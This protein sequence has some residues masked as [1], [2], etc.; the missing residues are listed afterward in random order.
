M[1]LEF[2]SEFKQSRIDSGSISL[3]KEQLILNMSDSPN[4]ST[5]TQT[6]K[7]PGLSF[8]LNNNVSKKFVVEA[9]TSNVNYSDINLLNQNSNLVAYFSHFAKLLGLNLST[10]LREIS[11]SLGLNVI[12]TLSEAANCFVQNGMLIKYFYVFYT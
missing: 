5:I 12:N 3:E 2:N 6:D 9:N 10:E 11:S 8:E 7:Y 4:C 1:P